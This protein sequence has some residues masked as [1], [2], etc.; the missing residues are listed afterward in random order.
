MS[1]NNS[2]NS[3]KKNKGKAGM[4]YDQ[5]RMLVGPPPM[6]S[7]VSQFYKFRYVTSAAVT[8]SFFNTD[9]LMEVLIMA[10]T[11]TNAVPI[12]MSVRLVSVKLWGVP[13]STVSI[14]PRSGSTQQFGSKL[15]NFVDTSSNNSSSSYV[16]WKPQPESFNGQ[17]F[18]GNS[19]LVTTT[20]PMFAFTAPSGATLDVTVEAQLNNNGSTFIYNRTVAGAIAGVIYCP[21]FAT[22]VV[23]VFWP[24]VS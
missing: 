17:W 3:N 20:Q 21:T 13:L 6:I 14:A 7:S 19:A 4:G 18:A 11:T 12:F 16:H 9:D 5:R 22:N 15:E 24:T 8:T 23:P 2:S 10:T 1:N